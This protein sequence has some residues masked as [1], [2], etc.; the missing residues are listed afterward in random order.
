MMS[1]GTLIIQFVLIPLQWLPVEKSLMIPVYSSIFKSLQRWILLIL[2]CCFFFFCVCLMRSIQCWVHCWNES[3]W[4]ALSCFSIIY[5]TV[6]GWR[7]ASLILYVCIR[8]CMSQSLHFMEG[9]FL[10]INNW[11]LMGY[12]RL[13]KRSTV[14]YPSLVN[15]QK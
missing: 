1:L 5:S 4:L 14:Y 8:I 9:N 2:G 13:Y 12:L 6:F 15:F 7:W 10:I 3:S 11:K